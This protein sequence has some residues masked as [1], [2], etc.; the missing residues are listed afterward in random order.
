MPRI[1]SEYACV[2]SMDECESIS[3]SVC[4]VMCGGYYIQ[5]PGISSPC[6]RC[7]C[8]NVSCQP[9]RRRRGGG[10][11]SALSCSR[12]G[13]QHLDKGEREKAA[14]K[15]KKEI[16][17]VTCET[18]RRIQADLATDGNM[19]H[20]K[21]KHKDRWMEKWKERERDWNNRAG[22]IGRE[23]GQQTEQ[24]D[25]SCNMF[26]H[27]HTECIIQWEWALTVFGERPELSRV[28]HPAGDPQLDS[29]SFQPL[30]P[31]Q[32]SP[33]LREAH[34]K[35]SAVTWNSYTVYSDM[36]LEYCLDFL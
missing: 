9:P 18:R 20:K 11:W 8:R 36:I 32:Q 17:E 22:Q 2:Q 34:H 14:R 12:S 15:R 24:T 3:V 30:Q 27:R 31:G 29:F 13:L 1:L 6:S 21:M 28:D 16:K 5:W 10:L 7:Q 35:T 23:N 25:Q 4:G 33:A 26:E 19:I